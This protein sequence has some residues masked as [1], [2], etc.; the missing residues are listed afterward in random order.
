MTSEQF[1]RAIQIARQNAEADRNNNAQVVQAGFKTQGDEP[2]HIRAV[3]L[4]GYITKL[5]TPQFARNFQQNQGVT[6]IDVKVIRKHSAQSTLE[7]YANSVAG[8]AGNGVNAVVEGVSS[9]DIGKLR[10]TVRSEQGNVIS[11]AQVKLFPMQVMLASAENTGSGIKQKGIAWYATLS[12]LQA[13][14]YSVEITDGTNTDKAQVNLYE[15]QAEAQ[16]PIANWMVGGKVMSV[17]LNTPD[18]TAIPEN[19]FFTIVELTGQATQTVNGKTVNVRCIPAKALGEA[20][21]K[22]KW[23]EPHTKHEVLLKEWK[24]EVKMDEPYIAPQNMTITNVSM[25]GTQ[26]E[27]RYMVELKLLV[28]DIR[29]DADCTNGIPIYTPVNARMQSAQAGTVKGRIISFTKQASNG[30]VSTYIAKVEFSNGEAFDNRDKSKGLTVNL[31]TSTGNSAI[32]SHTLNVA[33]R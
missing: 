12:G 1:E 28:A 24:T 20:K 4:Y 23:I 17:R 33:L 15:P 6:A 3:K 8:F 31:L 13:G 19:Q 5:L 30:G 27:H 10:A 32:T 25:S 29:A 16:R 21:V 2:K 9:T 7:I 18:G 11:S 26:P 14:T 22:L